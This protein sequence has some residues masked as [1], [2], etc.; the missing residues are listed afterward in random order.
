MTLNYNDDLIDSSRM[1]KAFS[2]HNTEKK[3]PS[4]FLSVKRKIS[5]VLEKYISC[6]YFQN[7]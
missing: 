5:G 4:K 7:K 3:M 6:K 1:G 2:T